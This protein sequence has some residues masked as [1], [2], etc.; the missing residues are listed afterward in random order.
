MQP[1]IIDWEKMVPPIHQDDIP[2][3]LPEDEDLPE[4][5][6]KEKIAVA[7]AINLL[8]KQAMR[9]TAEVFTPAM[10][11]TREQDIQDVITTIAA[12]ALP[13]LQDDPDW[14]DAADDQ[15]VEISLRHLRPLF[16]KEARA[17]FDDFLRG[18]D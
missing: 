7:V 14:F 1:I 12:K 2:V 6:T 13:I 3:V 10:W 18:K 5:V 9:G 11:P 4:T 15:M 8:S 16:I 17:Q